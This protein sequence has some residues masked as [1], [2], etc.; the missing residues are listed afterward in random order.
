MRIFQLL[1]IEIHVFPKCLWLCTVLVLVLLSCA[2]IKK[3]K[4][5][6]KKKERLVMIYVL[7]IYV[8][9]SLISS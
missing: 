8:F 5:G 2:I 1:V 3:K 6:K 7:E 4:R 9:K